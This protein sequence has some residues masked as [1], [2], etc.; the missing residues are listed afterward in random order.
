MKD[1]I[2]IIW[3]RH[4]LQSLFNNKDKIQSLSWFIYKGVVCS[5][6]TDDIERYAM[7]K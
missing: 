4:K 3:S 1:L 7:L 2:D 6:D 5:C